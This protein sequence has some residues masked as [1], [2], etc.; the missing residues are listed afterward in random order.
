M[1]GEHCGRRKILNKQDL[2][3]VT[4]EKRVFMQNVEV[5]HA[6]SGFALQYMPSI[7]KN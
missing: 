6:H 3:E 5:F 1:L 4:L 7:Q 2:A